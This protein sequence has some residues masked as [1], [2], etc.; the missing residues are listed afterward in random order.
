MVGAWNRDAGWGV[1]DSTDTPSGCWF[2]YSNLWTLQHPPLAAGESLEIRGQSGDVEIGETVDFDWESVQQDGFSFRAVD[3]R[4]RRKP[5][6]R[7][8]AFTV[9]G[10]LVPWP[11]ERFGE[12]PYPDLW[13]DEGVQ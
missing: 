2:Y 11:V 7:T 3:V 13:I 5:P 10:K 8:I 6:R 9:H 1:I 4:P 12:I